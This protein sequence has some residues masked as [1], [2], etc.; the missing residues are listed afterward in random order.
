MR[1]SSPPSEADMAY[2]G[3]TTSRFL[4]TALAAIP[5]F[6]YAF[7]KERRFAYANPTMLTLFGLP[8]ERMLGRTFEELG[9]PADLADRLNGHIEHVFRT[10]ETVEDEVFYRSPTGYAAY[11]SF[12]WGPVRRDE[13]SI[14][15]VVGV[16]RDT[17][18]RHQFEDQLSESEARLRAAT[19]LVGVGIY[20]WDPVTGKLEWDERVRAMWGLH[21]TSP[22]N[23]AVF[24]SAIHPDDLARVQR[25]VKDCADPAGDGLYNLEYRVIG[26]DDGVTRHISTKGRT[27]FDNGRA[28]SFIG[29]AIDVTRQRAAEAA[30]RANEAQFRSFADHSSNLIWIGDPTQDA[31][32]YRSA[33]Y[34]RIWGQPRDEAAGTLVEWLDDVHQDDREQVRQALATVKQGEMTK[35]DYRL[36]RPSDKAIRHLHDTSFPILDEDGAVYRIGGITEDLTPTPINHVYV[37]SSP[38]GEARRLANM[39]RS[40]G[41]SVRVFSTANAFLDIA[42]M[43]LPGCVLVDV[44][45]D[46]SEGLRIPRELKARSISM[47]ALVLDGERAEIDA[48]VSAMKAG[49]ADYLVVADE[50]A[51]RTALVIAI[52]ECSLQ[53]HLATSDESAAGRLA[54]LTSREHDVL[55]GLVEGGTNK[56]IALKLGISPRTVELH[57]A[58]VMN[59]LNASSLTELLQIAWAAGLRPIDAKTNI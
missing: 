55:V 34:E 58:Q 24:Y 45:K 53:Q 1:Q 4:E 23:K 9:Y 26:L 10:G 51:L 52:G 32:I 59:R 40:R 13:G 19:E 14:E 33:A 37:V 49:A 2:Q 7:D 43:L 25:A 18:Q 11:F 5:D 39:L 48:A 30:I 46:K 56:T 6:V 57:R 8:A 29:A 17:S 42:Q 20:S 27:T 50:N 16:S 3:S 35:F 44:R 47:P 15:L 36:I 38:A 12:L 54:R 22:V 21:P 41:Y 28:I 31:I